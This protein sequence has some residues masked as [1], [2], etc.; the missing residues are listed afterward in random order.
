VDLQ[1]DQMWDRTIGDSGKGLSRQFASY[2]ADCNNRKELKKRGATGA[3]IDA[4]QSACQRAQAEK[5]KFE[6]FY[7]RIMEQRGE[8]KAFQAAS[9]SHRQ[10]L[11]AEASRI[12]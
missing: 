10:A 11:V 3:A 2:P 1:V 7:R 4:W 9:G 5:A 6:P 12:Q 8:L